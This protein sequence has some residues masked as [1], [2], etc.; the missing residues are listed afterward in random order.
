VEISDGLD[1]NGFDILINYD[2]VRLSLADWEYGD[3]LDVDDPDCTR[4]INQPGY[5]E[6]ACAQ[7]SQTEV[8]GDG[9]FLRMTFDTLGLG[10]PDVTIT[11]A[12]LYDADQAVTYPVRQHGY[13]EV[14]NDPTFTPTQT[15]TFTSTMTLTATIT[16]TPTITPTISTTSSTN[17]ATSIYTRTI[18]PSPTLTTTPGSELTPTSTSTF[19][20]NV[21]P[22][23]SATLV[24]T[25]MVT[26]AVGTMTPTLEPT[27]A[28][29]QSESPSPGDI[30]ATAVSTLI[31]T[32][33]PAPAETQM[34]TEGG[35]APDEETGAVTPSP[36]GDLVRGVWQ[37]VLWGGL[38][39]G[40]AVLLGV[41]ILYILRN[42]S[43]GDEE[44]DLLL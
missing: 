21:T 32:E 9:I 36:T 42:R 17:T 15:T 22:G 6:L 11:E 2:N 16:P 40:G 41:A 3:Y 37:A 24:S 39:L 1:V 31:Q 26:P 4:L 20:S 27:A 12:M 7:G 13:I 8:D 5:F 14:T 44:E 43:R 23:P 18:T 34:P 28:V 25:G 35:A 30:T 33:E 29:T 19:M 38:I 10:F